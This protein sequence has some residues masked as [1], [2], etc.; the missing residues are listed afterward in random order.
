MLFSFITHLMQAAQSATSCSTAQYKPYF[1]FYGAPWIFGTAVVILI[2][3]ILL[4]CGAQGA[5]IEPRGHINASKTLLTG[6]RIS[7]FL[8]ER[9]AES[10]LRYKNGNWLF[11][12]QIR[13]LEVH[14]AALPNADRDFCLDW[15]LDS[16]ASCHFCNDSTKFVSMKKCNISI[17]TAKKGESL[18]A[19]GIGNCKIAVMTANGTLVNLLLHDVLY[20][21]EARRNL[22]SVSK[23]SQDQFQVVMPA[24]NSIFCPGIYNCRKGKTSLEHSIPIASV[25]NLFHVHTCSDA[26]VKRHDRPEN[27]YILWHRRLGFMPLATIQQMIDSCQG[28]ED[29]QG[30]S[31]PRNYV[32]ANARRGKAVSM[33]QPKS[34][35]TRAD[36]PLQVVHFDIFGPCKNPSFA[37][38]SYCVVL[39]DDH[40]RYT[41]VYTVKNKSDVLDVL[42]RFYADTSI[43]RSKHPLCCFHRDNAGE[44]FSAAAVQWMTDNGIKSSSSTPHEPWQNGRAEVQIRVLCNIARTNMIASGLTGKFWARAIFYAADISNIQY[45][46]DLKMSPHQS[47]YGIK[48]DVSKCQPFG[49]ECWLYV[50]ADQ[51]HDK[52]FDARGEPGIYCGRSTLENRS[53]Y[54]VYVPGRSRPTFVS[55]NNV[56]FGNK[57]PLAKDAPDVIDNGEVVLDFPPEANASD[58]NSSSVDSIMDQTETLYIL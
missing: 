9:T 26:E 7:P 54:V 14:V 12:Y 3:A 16:G 18:H 45:R 37:G 41:W 10:L 21:P 28:L 35:P 39:I 50:R 15:C 6:Q 1:R 5:S 19:I 40:T 58:I 55:T 29:L 33:D 48:P 8:S 17:S 25:G 56:V 49:V 47:L 30:I 2:I 42:K 4:Q 44:N 52:K 31:M 22:L 38:H 13:D 11:S 32:S 36:Q 51:R 46:D 27:K 53:S 20:V 57:C 43:I 34:N 24:N 23:L